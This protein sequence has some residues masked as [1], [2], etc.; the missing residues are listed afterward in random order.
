MLC[1]LGFGIMAA[2][3]REQMNRQIHTRAQIEELLGT[4]CLAVLPLFKGNKGVL[5]Q[6][7]ATKEFA[8]VQKNY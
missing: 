2:F 4:S 8:D 3:V 5:K 7:R 1:G 6:L